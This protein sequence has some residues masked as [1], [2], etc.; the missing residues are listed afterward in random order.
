M[1]VVVITCSFFVGNDFLPN[2]PG[3]DIAEGA[4]EMIFKT[5]KDLM[6]KLGGYCGMLCVVNV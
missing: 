3:L 2:L 1:L 5:Y 4:L 6:P